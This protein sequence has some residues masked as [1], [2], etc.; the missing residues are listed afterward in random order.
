[1]CGGGEGGQGQGLDFSKENVFI[2]ALD[3]LP[4]VE[5]GLVVGKRGVS[6][7]Q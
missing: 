1:M 6:R 5:R 2:E 7:L 4:P 3:R